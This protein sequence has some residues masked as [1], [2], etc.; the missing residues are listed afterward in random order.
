MSSNWRF[1]L[2][3][4]T[5]RRFTQSDP[6]V[7]VL[8]NNITQARTEVVNNSTLTVSFLSGGACLPLGRP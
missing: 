3:I 5:V 2:L 6:Y 1:S 4:Q 8:V 7:R